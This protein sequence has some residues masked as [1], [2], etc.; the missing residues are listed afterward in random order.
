MDYPQG[1]AITSHLEY[2]VTQLSYSI[3]TG[4]ESALEMLA[5]IFTTFPQVI[6]CTICRWSY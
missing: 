6:Y 2:F 1:A 5:T 4:R 3:D